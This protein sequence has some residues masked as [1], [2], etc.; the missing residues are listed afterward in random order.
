MKTA[1]DIS[2]FYE[3]ELSFKIYICIEK[4]PFTQRRQ[5]AG[6]GSFDEK[7]GENDDSDTDDFDE[8]YNDKS[9]LNTGMGTGMNNAANQLGDT[10]KKM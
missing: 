8:F 6:Q 5:T 4:N 7:K 10:G 2:L 3:Y 9:F 1:T